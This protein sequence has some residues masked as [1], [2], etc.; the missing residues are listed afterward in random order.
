MEIAVGTRPGTP[1]RGSDE[2]YVAEIV[3]PGIVLLAVAHGFGRIRERP[4]PTIAAQ[5]VRD[6]LK[7]RVRR[8]RR[9]PRAAL[10]AAFSAANARVYAHSGSTDDYVASGT[11]MTAALIVGDHAFVGHVGATR[12]YLGRDGALTSLTSDDAVGEGP[13]RLL[14]RTLGTQPTLE[15]GLAHLR[16][17]HGDALVLSSGALHELLGEDEI[18]DALRASASSEDA[19]ARLLAIA[20]IRGDGAATVIVGRAFNELSL[21]A[22]K[23]RPQAREAAV[24]LFAMLAATIVAIVMLHAMFTP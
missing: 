1:Q 3:A 22:S 23:R 16:L 7:R 13:L 17:M 12:A 10:S 18:A 8:E 6:S 11:S 24:A 15:P 14:T 5:A 19:T 2:A 21:D 20:G 4:A 9:D